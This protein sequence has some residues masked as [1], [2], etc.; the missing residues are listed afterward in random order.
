MS[1][2]VVLAE[3]EALRRALYAFR[4]R[5]YVDELKENE[6]RYVR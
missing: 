4:H 6:A 1:T 5:I 2:S 3:D